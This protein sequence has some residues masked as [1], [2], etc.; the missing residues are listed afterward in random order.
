L[1]TQIWEETE[2]KH[3]ELIQDKVTNTVLNPGELVE[4]LQEFQEFQDLVPTEVVRV[5]LVTSAEKE[6]CL[7]H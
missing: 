6:E 2:D 5:L 3:M 7:P 4:Q 1:F